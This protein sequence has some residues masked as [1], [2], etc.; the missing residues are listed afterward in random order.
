MG[1]AKKIA[2]LFRRDTT[3]SDATASIATAGPRMGV[4]VVYPGTDG[5]LAI[6]TVFRCIHLISESAAGLTFQ[7][8]VRKGNRFVADTDSPL[9]YLLTVQPQPDMSA[10]AFM[11]TAVQQML[12][13]GNAYIY[14]MRSGGDITG[15][16]LCHRRCVSHDALNS[17]YTINDPYNGI[18]GTFGEKDIIHLYLHTSDGLTGESVLQHASRTLSIAA[19][20]E[21]ETLSRFANG[22]A[23]R[24]F[25]TGATD[26]LRGFGDTQDS[27][28]EKL[29]AKFDEAFKTG[30]RIVAMPGG[31]DFKPLSLSSTDMQFLESRKFTV[32][33]ICR[34]FGVNP[35]YVFDDGATNYKS[36]ETANVAFLSTT[37][38]PILRRIESEFNRKLVPENLHTRQKFAFDR[39]GVYAMDLDSLANY[40]LKTIQ[41]GIYTVNDWRRM[42]NQPEVPGGDAVFV[43][44]NLQ[45]LDGAAAATTPTGENY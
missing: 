17:T 34:F 39:R 8:L 31:A 33:E 42:E 9:H 44:T 6:S 36:A 2:R 23:V 43:S 37:L 45:R 7:N 19:T 32:R 18:W 5:S 13:D 38:N 20:G 22:G 12:V 10:F 24:G 27:E 16:F 1:I 35:A 14:P 26:G 21:D 41:A 15:L 4:N 40:Q 28:K 3:D 30:D 11:A 29:A 25:I